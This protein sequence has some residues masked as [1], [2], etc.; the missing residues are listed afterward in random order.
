MQKKLR[1]K[2]M[3]KYDMY[4]MYIII[5]WIFVDK[6]NRMILNLRYND[7]N[8]ILLEQ[9]FEEKKRV[10]IYSTLKQIFK[11]WVSSFLI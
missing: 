9:E 6:D 5:N 8:N 4:N 2:N 1:D 3:Y 11:V 7:H 10:V